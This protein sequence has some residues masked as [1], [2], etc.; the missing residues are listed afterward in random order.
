MV[1]STPH[2]QFYEMNIRIGNDSTPSATPQKL[3]QDTMV[4]KQTQEAALSAI[5]DGYTTI[6]YNFLREGSMLQAHDNCEFTGFDLQKLWSESESRRLHKGD[7]VQPNF[8]K[9]KQYTRL[10]LCLTSTAY[11]H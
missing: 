4:L 3:L 8:S 11:I 10:T 9:I 1:Q 2:A 5:L 6:V 7:S